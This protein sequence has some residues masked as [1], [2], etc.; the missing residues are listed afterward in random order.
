[1]ILSSRALLLS[2]CTFAVVC[3]ATTAQAGMVDEENAGGANVAAKASATAKAATQASNCEKAVEEVNEALEKGQTERAERLKQKKDAVCSQQ[4][5]AAKAD[6][7]KVVEEIKADADYDR[8][9]ANAMGADAR[10]Q[11]AYNPPQNMKINGQEISWA[12]YES[13]RQ[14]GESK[15]FS[16]QQIAGIAGR[17]QVESNAFSPTKDGSTALGDSGTSSGKAQWH[18]ERGTALVN[19]IN[20]QR[21]ARADANNTSYNKASLAN[22]GKSAGGLK[23]SSYDQSNYVFD[24]LPSQMS[25]ENYAALKNASS[26]EEAARIFTK[27]YERP[28]NASGQAWG[29]AG[30]NATTAFASG[31]A[32]TKGNTVIPDTGQ[33]DSRQLANYSS[34]SGVGSGSGT[35][36][37][38][39]SGSNTVNNLISQMFGSKGSSLLNSSGS[40]NPL[41]NALNS[42]MGGGSGSGSSSSS[43]SSSSGYGSSTGTTDTAATG[44][45]RTLVSTVTTINTDGSIESV[46]T[47]SD[48]LK[49]TSKTAPTAT[50]DTESVTTTLNSICA[51]TKPSSVDAFMLMINQCTA[52][53]KS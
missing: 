20:E 28:A 9:F 35:G 8:K 16:D 27:Y 39:G 1:M 32:N 44:N 18:N 10:N 7:K 5:S 51:G 47:Y 40:G 21:E 14:I 4:F 30:G 3:L 41:A 49:L 52:A 12:K 6:E 15:G 25:K 23:F 46:Q 36:S 42:I 45:E 34:G 53:Y 2:V 50:A 43:V 38:V 22:N 48:G 11:E 29:L 19:Y 13:F 37:S 33:W 17:L 24:E 31:L 26:A